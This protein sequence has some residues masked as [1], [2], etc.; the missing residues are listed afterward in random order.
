LDGEAQADAV[1][2]HQAEHPNQVWAMGFQFDATADS[3]WLKVLKLIDE[4]SDQCP[5]ALA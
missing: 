2:R 5:Q 1:E 3:R 4:H